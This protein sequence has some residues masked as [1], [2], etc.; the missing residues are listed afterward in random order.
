M[1]K[2]IYKPKECTALITFCYKGKYY[3]LGFDFSEKTGL[4][5]AKHKHIIK[6]CFKLLSDG[7]LRKL[8]E[9]T[10]GVEKWPS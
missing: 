5:I 10:G 7:A 6:R 8:M 4:D 1:K 2:N 9:L 3:S